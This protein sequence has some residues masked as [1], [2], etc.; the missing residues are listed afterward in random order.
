MPW[1]NMG[2]VKILDALR[3]GALATGLLWAAGSPLA[4]D[5]DETAPGPTTAT[6]GGGAGGAGGA[7]TGTR[8]VADPSRL[9]AACTTSDECGGLPCV[10]PDPSS[11]PSGFAGGMCTLSCQDADVCEELVPE[12]RC[13]LGYCLEPCERGPTDLDQFDP[14]KCHGRE[15]VACYQR[16]EGG[17]VRNLCLPNCNADADCGEGMYCEP[18]EGY[19]RPFLPEGAPDGTMCTTDVECLG[20]C[21]GATP[22]ERGVCARRCTLGHLPSCDWD[23]SSPAT[24]ACAIPQEPDVA[25]MGDGGYCGLLCDCDDDCISATTVCVPFGDLPHLSNPWAEDVVTGSGRLGVCLD[26]DQAA[27]GSPGI[28]CEGGGGAGGAGGAAGG[29]GGAGGSA[30]AGGAPGGSGGAGGAG[31]Q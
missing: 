24:H 22:A 7:S 5:G 25:G 12:A 6:G 30:G 27:G 10:V 29:A 14:D 18:G 3:L 28:P 9:G 31:G 13:V 26:S 2:R 1:G 21:W 19:C 20:V 16:L 8:P 11:D 15:D 4:C 23:G 17:A